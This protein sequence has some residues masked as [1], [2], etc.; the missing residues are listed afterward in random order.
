MAYKY[1]NQYNYKNIPYPS[2]E[3][4]NATIASGGCGV[5]C[6]AMIVSNLTDKIVDPKAMASYA[7][8]KGAR[9]NGGTEMTILAKALCADY[10]LDFKTTNDENVLITHLKSGGMAVANVGGSRQGYVGVFSD[11]GHFIVI[12]GL[13]SDG[14]I[15]VLDP[16]NY[17]GKFNKTGRKGKVIVSGNNCIC[18][19]SVLTQ[20]TANRPIGYW[21]FERREA[22]VP[23]WMKKIMEDAKAVGLISSDHNPNEP[24]TKWFV[25]AIA[26]NVLKI[27]RG[28]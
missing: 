5:C 3:L 6:G 23:E 28:K 25:L 12:A 11:G 16:G 13:T 1:Y 22:E 7:I 14:R 24:A 26:L 10:L 17:S 2:E 19:I 27:V 4:K 20:D 18:D 9:V 8:K 15:I 21:L